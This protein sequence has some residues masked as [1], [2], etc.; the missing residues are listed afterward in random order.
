MQTTVT[1]LA[2]NEH[3]TMEKSHPKI[4]QAEGLWKQFAGRLQEA[5]GVLTDDDLDRY[6]G[7]RE[8]LEGHI[9]QK[10]GEK[11]EAIHERI[12]EIARAVKYRF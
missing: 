5:W 8:Q 11:R 9:Q 7:A 12:E 10:T 2:F 1:N 4:Q 6:E 3:N